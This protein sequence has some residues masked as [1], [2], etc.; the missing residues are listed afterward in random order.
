MRKIK[1]LACFATHEQAYPKGSIREV[2]DAEAA[3][4]VKNGDAE[5]F[6]DSAS[7]D[8]GGA[9][10]EIEVATNESRESAAAR[11]ARTTRVKP[12]QAPQA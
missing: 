1:L 8:P 5:Y 7:T 3:R 4:F 12:H 2:S 10:G 6:N 9:T 11:I